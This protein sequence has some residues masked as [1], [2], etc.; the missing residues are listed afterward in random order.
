MAHSLS[1]LAAQLG[2]TLRGAGG[3]ALEAA[4]PADLSFVQDSKQL[5]R[6]KDCRAAALVTTAELAADL[7][8]APFP[9]LM[10]SDPAAT[11]VS[12][13]QIVQP[14]R[15]RPA[16]G[17]ATTACISA[18]AKIAE[19]CY[20]GPGAVIGDDAVIGRGCDIYPGV[21]IGPGCR[22]SCI[23]RSSCTLT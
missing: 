19:D 5:S 18:S 20:V 11:F 22:L 3:A 2:A 6:L 15:R 8:L 13:L 10:V 17:I 14:A 9:C 16:R 7:R 4:G 23:H 21:V 1:A 12:I